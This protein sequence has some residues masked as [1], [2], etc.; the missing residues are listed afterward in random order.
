MNLKLIIYKHIKHTMY[1]PEQFVKLTNPDGINKGFQFKKGLNEDIHEFNRN[2]ECAEGGL[3]FCRFKD[4]SEWIL[5]Y[6]DALI[7][8]V[9]IPE[10]EEVIEYDTK[11]KAKLYENYDLF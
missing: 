2:E 8:K 9:E 11:L 7:W 1:Q 6:G 4:I 10:G 5:D 3:Y